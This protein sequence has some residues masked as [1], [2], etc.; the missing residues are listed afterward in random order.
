MRP[1]GVK[2][3]LLVF[4]RNLDE[5]RH[6]PHSPRPASSSSVIVR[7]AS[8][9]RL[10]TPS[11]RRRACTGCE[12]MNLRIAK[13]YDYLQKVEILMQKAMKRPA[14]YLHSVSPV[15]SDRLVRPPAA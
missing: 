10:L 3:R 8:A 14:V 11:G 9:I 15:R 12:S 2:P 4:P 5:C 6:F 7:R 1:F 13:H